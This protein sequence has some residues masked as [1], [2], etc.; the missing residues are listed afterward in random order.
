MM[1]LFCSPCGKA[2]NGK[3]CVHFRVVVELTETRGRAKDEKPLYF[4]AFYKQKSN[5]RWY[6]I[7]K[8]KKMI[9]EGKM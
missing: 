8:G 9:E 1:P 2:V 5:H 6:S 3:Y 4:T 7:K